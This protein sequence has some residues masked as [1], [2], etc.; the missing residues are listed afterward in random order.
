[1]IGAP[2]TSIWGAFARP[3]SAES[4]SGKYSV[5]AITSCTDSI[6]LEQVEKVA[7]PLRQALADEKQALLEDIKFVQDCL[8]EENSTM[9][10]VKKTAVSSLP[11]TEELRVVNSK[12]EKSWLEQV[13]KPPVCNFVTSCRTLVFIHKCV[14]AGKGLSFEKDA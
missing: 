7:A 6:N 11:T 13:F 4:E 5:E 1:M 8:E 9:E 10:S 12:L 3:D 2:V 14:Y